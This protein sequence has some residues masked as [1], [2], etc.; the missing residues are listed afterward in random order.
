MLRYSFQLFIPISFP[1]YHSGNLFICAWSWVDYSQCIHSVYTVPKVCY[2]SF[3]Y[4]I[5][6]G[7]R[8]HIQY[9]Y[10]YIR[11]LCLIYHVVHA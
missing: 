7:I 9:S 11:G 3:K 6:V 5:N 8:N 1:N 4:K 2:F 10:V